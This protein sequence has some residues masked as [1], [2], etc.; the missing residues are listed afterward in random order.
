MEG[1]TTRGI[2]LDASFLIEVNLND[3]KKTCL[4]NGIAIKKFVH[5]YQKVCPR[6]GVYFNLL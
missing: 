3:I 6:Y 5:R 1:L 4:Q 2:S